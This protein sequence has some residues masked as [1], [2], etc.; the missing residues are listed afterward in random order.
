MATKVLAVPVAKAAPRKAA[1]ALTEFDVARL[2]LAKA[3][4]RE[5]ILRLQAGSI[6]LQCGFD[7]LCATSH[8]RGQRDIEHVLDALDEIANALTLALIHA[9]QD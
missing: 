1:M 5:N 2:R 8:E 6:A 7:R 9:P 4:A 3:L